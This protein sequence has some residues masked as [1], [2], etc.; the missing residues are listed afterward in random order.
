MSSPP[1]PS[2][3]L[4]VSMDTARHGTLTRSVSEGKTGQATA[5]VGVQP[6]GVSSR[7]K[8]ELQRYEPAYQRSA[9]PDKMGD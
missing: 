6:L 5:D 2:L 3:T 4:R 7:L 1:P 8:P 9:K